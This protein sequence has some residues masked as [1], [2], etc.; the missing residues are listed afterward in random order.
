[1]LPN[2]MSE[3]EERQKGTQKI[4]PAQGSQEST[5]ETHGQ[6]D[7]FPSGEVLA[8]NARASKRKASRLP[9]L[10]GFPGREESARTGFVPLFRSSKKR[11]NRLQS[12][13]GHGVAHGV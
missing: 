13:P 1:M 2:L 7:P 3:M 10:T 5:G 8:Q 11:S 6:R 4:K 12:L 9:V